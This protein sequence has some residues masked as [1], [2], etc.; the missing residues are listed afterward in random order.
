MVNTSP[1]L[2]IGRFCSPLS[3]RFNTDKAPTTREN[4][5][6]SKGCQSGK[7]KKGKNASI[8]EIYMQTGLTRFL[9]HT[10]NW[11][12][13]TCLSRRFSSLLLSIDHYKCTDYR[14]IFL[15]SLFVISLQWTLPYLPYQSITTVIHEKPSQKYMEFE[16]IA[17]FHGFL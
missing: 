1:S 14:N 2:D 8:G 10:I 16:N 15:K 7:G 4:Q 12:C 9:S 17:S 3:W 11:I 6:M 5:R 13:R